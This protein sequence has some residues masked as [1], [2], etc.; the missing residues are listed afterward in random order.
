MALLGHGIDIVE[1]ERIEQMVQRHG[2]HFL[3]RVFTPRE[4]EYCRRN[5]KRCSQH[6]AGRFAAKEAVLKVL[7]TGWR[8]KIAWTDIEI[9]PE[10]SGQPKLTLSGECRTIA[11]QLGITEWHVSIS[12]IDTHATASAIGVRGPVEA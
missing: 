8:G 3:D 6:L 2:A 7:G 9:L 12:H 10:P 11:E 4:Q 5:A 1:T